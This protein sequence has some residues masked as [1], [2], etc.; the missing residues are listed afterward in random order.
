MKHAKIQHPIDFDIDTYLE[1]ILVSEE[2][3]VI[4]SVEDLWDSWY[5]NP[6]SEG[7]DCPD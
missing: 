5:Q 4:G 1:D 2:E 6:L 7:M 3:E